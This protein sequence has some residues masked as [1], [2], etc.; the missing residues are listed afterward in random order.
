VERHDGIGKLL[1]VHVGIDEN[2]NPSATF[3]LAEALVKADKEFDMLILPVSTT[4]M[5]GNTMSIS[6]KSNGIIL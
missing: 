1:I 2:V 3:K 5:P 6:P 4:V